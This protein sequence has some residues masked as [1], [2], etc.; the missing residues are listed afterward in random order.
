MMRYFFL[1][2]FTGSLIL[3]SCNEPAP[4][5][6]TVITTE[7]MQ[8][9]LDEDELLQLLDVRTSEEYEVGHLKDSQNVCVTDSDFKE[10][11]A[12]FDKN[13]PVYVYCKSGG[14]SARAAKILSEMGFTKIYDLDGG[15]TAWDEAGMETEA[16]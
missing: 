14:R 15:I 5:K 4:K 8:Q 16:Q 2:M 12:K 3:H 6:V 11:A 7:E 13:K 10:K 9:A 1:L